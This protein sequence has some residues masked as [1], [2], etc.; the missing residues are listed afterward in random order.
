MQLR[1]SLFLCGIFLKVALLYGQEYTF[2]VLLNKGDNKL[3]TESGESAN[4]TTGQQISGSGTI[5]TNSDSYL[6]LLH[7]TGKVLQLKGEGTHTISQL[8][9]Q[10]IQAKRNSR[11]DQYIPERLSKNERSRSNDG[12]RAVAEVASRTISVALPDVV[13]L[14]GDMALIKWDATTEGATYEV[15]INDIFGESIFV[16]QVSE[17][18]ISIN[19]EELTTDFKLFQI[20]VKDVA[21]GVSSKSYKIKKIE[22]SDNPEVIEELQA[23]VADIDKESP[24]EML[25]L[26]TFYQQKGL[27]LDA[28]TNYEETINTFPDITD[29]DIYYQDFLGAYIVE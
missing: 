3:R 18:F 8:Q 21:S 4:L 22:P 17:N 5:V 25:I 13:D 20:M 9:E 24:L 27:Y 11:F 15:S 23:L 29:L 10:V 19:F 6:G 1:A 7:R 26:S 16:E 28:L 2:K 12:T 14:Y